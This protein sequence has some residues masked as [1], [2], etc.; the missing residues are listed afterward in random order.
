MFI[1]KQR[2]GIYLSV[3]SVAVAAI[4]FNQPAV[5]RSLVV[6]VIIVSRRRCAARRRQQRVLLTA[7]EGRINWT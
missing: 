7:T 6:I 1:R 3:T 5:G 4:F 2:R